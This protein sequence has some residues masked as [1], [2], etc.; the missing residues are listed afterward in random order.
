MGVAVDCAC[1]VVVEERGG[2]S[3]LKE[4]LPCF[5]HPC[6][7]VSPCDVFL[8]FCWLHCFLLP[9][10]LSGELM[11]F[12]DQYLRVSRKVA[13]TAGVWVSAGREEALRPIK[14]LFCGFFCSGCLTNRID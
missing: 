11:D 1:R 10:L 8:F 2:L 13:M 14:V 9:Q 7:S 4:D 6:W 3:Q 12:S 5:D